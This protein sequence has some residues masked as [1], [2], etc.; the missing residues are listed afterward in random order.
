MSPKY[1]LS[2]PTLAIQVF[3]I[4]FYLAVVTSVGVTRTDISFLTHYS[5]FEDTFSLAAVT[6]VEVAKIYTC[7]LTFYFHFKDIYWSNDFSFCS[8]SIQYKRCFFF[9]FFGKNVDT[10]CKR[11][12]AAILFL[13]LIMPKTFLVI[14]VLFIGLTLVDKRLL[15]LLSTRYVNKR[16]VSG[17]I[18]FEVFILLF[19]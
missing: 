1:L 16:R 7:F 13:S 14:F 9:F 4:V 6:G 12:M 17:L 15:G 11:V 18:F 19:G 2:S 3:L 10:C 8:G 5:Y